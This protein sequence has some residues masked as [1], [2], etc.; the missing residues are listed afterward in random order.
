[1]ERLTKRSAD[2]T[3]VWFVDHEKDGLELEP[4]EMEYRHS[5]MAIRRLAEYEDL[6]EHG[7]LLKPR[8]IPGDYVWEVNKERN[9]ISEYEV[10][11]IRYG[12]NKTFHY[13]WA[14]RY[15]IYSDLDGFR[16][17]DIN[18]TVFLSEEDAEAALKTVN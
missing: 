14:L 15:G 17:K 10:I 12:I 13:M 18:N 5:G 7:E 16:D 3:A 4:C 2:G 11:S 6:E 8:C 1:M 9:I